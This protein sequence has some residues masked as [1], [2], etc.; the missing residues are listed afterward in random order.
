MRSQ[1]SGL[2][3]L[4]P[5]HVA[6]IVLILLLVVTLAVLVALGPLA[7]LLVVRGK[8]IIRNVVEPHHGLVGVLHEQVLSVGQLHAHVDEHPQ[9]APPIFHGQV[10]LHG[11]LGRLELLRAEDDVARGVADVLARDVA[12]LDV[13]GAGEDRLDR[14]LG[15]L[16][17]VVLQLVGQ[18]GAA[19]LVELLPPL[20]SSRELP[21]PNYA[22]KD[23]KKRLTFNFM[24][25]KK[26]VVF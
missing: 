24:R 1:T 6:G 5:G 23:I 26:Q 20:D 12:E 7:V 13:V 8:R 25:K 16:V 11:E 21:I 19:L 18:D 10:D 22:R 15:Q 4:G 17:G 2:L 14:P 9:H 3:A